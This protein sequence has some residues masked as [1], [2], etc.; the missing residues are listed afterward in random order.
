DAER[1]AAFEQS[2]AWQRELG[3]AQASVLD[4]AQVA[5][6]VPEL[7]VEDVAG[8][9]FGARDGF[10]DGHLYCSL[11]AELARADGARIAGGAAVVQAARR[12]GGGW[13]L[14]TSGG[15]ELACDYV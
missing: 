9:L 4:G 3:V 11:L 12:A 5:R 15:E 1:L 7:A 10:L 14:R 13:R 6:L 8:G 2:V